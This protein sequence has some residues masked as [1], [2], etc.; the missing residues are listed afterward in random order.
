MKRFPEETDLMERGIEHR[1]YE[2]A[3][4]LSAVENDLVD[5]YLRG[6]R[7]R[8]SSALRRGPGKGDRLEP[9]DPILNYS[10]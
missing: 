4:R 7:D 3:S 8:I 10:S 1:R 6:A 5:A 9:H 2:F